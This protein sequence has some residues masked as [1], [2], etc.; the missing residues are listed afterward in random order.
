MVI[1]N[2]PLLNAGLNA[3]SALLLALGYAA[4]R[5]G[6]VQVHR[7][8]M[9]TALATSTIFLISYLT[10]HAIVGNVLFQGQGPI[11]T[12]YF[13]ILISH[14][15]LAVLNVPLILRV[16]YLA[17]RERF[18]EHR[19]LARWVWPSWMYVSVTGVVVYWMLY[20]L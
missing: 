10:Y 4:I 5:S 2:L 6:R 19:R 13:T 1:H 20:R 16:V 11:R 3:L 18:E 12:V 9:L 8:L 15:I 14:T 7:A 17:W